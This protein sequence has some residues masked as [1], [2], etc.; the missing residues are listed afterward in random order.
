M[1][2][3][4]YTI[5]KEN[6]AIL[7]FIAAVIF[8][9]LGILLPPLGYISSSV[10]ILIAQFLVMCATLLGLNITF[11]LMQKKFITEYKEKQLQ[12]DKQ[13]EDEQDVIEQIQKLAD[14]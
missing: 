9:F 8:G 13:K 1:K 6:L 2:I 5:L 7:S 11:D 14:K 3:I 10:L 4:N 12:I